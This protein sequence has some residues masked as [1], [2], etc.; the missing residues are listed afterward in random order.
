MTK[1]KTEIF[2]AA[3]GKAIRKT[4]DSMKESGERREAA[5]RTPSIYR[6]NR[7]N[8]PLLDDLPRE[9]GWVDAQVQFLVD[10]ASAGADHTV[11]RILLEPGG[12]YE[13]HRHRL[14]DAFL[15]VLKGQGHVLSDLGEEPSAEGDVIYAPRGSWHGFRNTSADEVVLLWG[16]MGT[17]SIAASGYEVEPD[18]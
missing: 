9:N 14:C 11:G 12:R 18:R 8:V 5:A 17:G 15:V 7:R 2:A 10:K 3:L 6:I 4:T 1:S 16:L 13:R